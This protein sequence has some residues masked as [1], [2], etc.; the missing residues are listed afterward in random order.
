MLERRKFTTDHLRFAIE[1]GEF[2][3]DIT[4]SAP[5][6]ACVM[7]QSWCPQWLFM[8]SWIK[9]LARETDETEGLTI[10]T[11]ET[12]YDREKLFTDFRS[13]KEQVWNNWEV[14]YVRYYS[15]GRLVHESNF[16]SAMTFVDNFRQNS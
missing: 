4:E 9:Q 5:L 7:S 15:G 10:H 11:W 3:A 1:T 14:P 12:E 16:V 13:F 2:H 6:V 8:R